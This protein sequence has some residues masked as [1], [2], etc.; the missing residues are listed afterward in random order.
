M[1]NIKKN[2]TIMKQTYINPELNV[3]KLQPIQMLV[4][5]LQTSETEAQDNTMLSREFDYEDEEEEYEDY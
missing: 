3:V 4:V 1:F 2:H 5:S